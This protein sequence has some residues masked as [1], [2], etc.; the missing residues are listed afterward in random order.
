MSG[1]GPLRRAIGKRVAPP[2]FLAFIG[3]LPL[4]TFAHQHLIGPAPW[5]QS[6][7]I[8]F[9]IAAAVFLVSLIPL[10]K[11][12]GAEAIRQR[13]DAND[14]NS[15]LVLV[16]TSLLTVVIMSA[17]AG[18]L[19]AARQGDL[20]ATAQLVATLLLSWLFANS[21]YALHYAHDFY[22]AHAGG[23]RDCGGMV[24]PGTLQPGYADFAYFAFTVGMTFQTS[25]IAIT[26]TRVR[27]VAVLHSFAAFIFNIGVIAFIINALGGG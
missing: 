13:A 23:G 14:A 11:E 27:G 1:R 12:R 25:D 26:A 5:T 8:G 24:F 20:A 3:L 9:D 15:V 10:L 4:G 6:L 21:V 16:M 7:A 17:I 19:P 18:E 2:R 22:S